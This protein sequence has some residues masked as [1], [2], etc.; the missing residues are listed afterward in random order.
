MARLQPVV[1]VVEDDPPIRRFL[2]TGLRTHGF[3]VFEAETGRQGLV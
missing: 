1:V 2:R 3:E